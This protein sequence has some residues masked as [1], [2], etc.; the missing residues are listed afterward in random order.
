[1]RVFGSLASLRCT[2]VPVKP[3]GRCSTAATGLRMFYH[4]PLSGHAAASHQQQIVPAVVFH[5][6]QQVAMLVLRQ[7][8]PNVQRDEPVGDGGLPAPITALG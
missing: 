5:V 1:M 2:E 4:R 7:R 6:A 3:S 8:P